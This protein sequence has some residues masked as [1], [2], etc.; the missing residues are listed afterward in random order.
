MLSLKKRIN[1]RV[2]LL[3]SNDNNLV[4][5]AS[6]SSTK[7]KYWYISWKPNVSSE[8]SNP[9]NIN[10]LTE[11]EGDENIEERPS[12]L[13]FSIKHASNRAPHAMN[14]LVNQ[15]A[16]KLRFS[17]FNQNCLD[18]IEPDAFQ[19]Q[20]I[21]VNTFNF[22]PKG[23]NSTVSNFNQSGGDF[24]NYNTNCTNKNKENLDPQTSCINTSSYD[25]SFIFGPKAR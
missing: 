11:N 8:W 19:C 7:S 23:M 5:I 18:E 24:R 15:G 1:S 14:V 6:N 22:S 21:T 10:L 3:D 17:D 16:M 2:N 20:N 13:Y 9:N 25:S 4:N 12:D